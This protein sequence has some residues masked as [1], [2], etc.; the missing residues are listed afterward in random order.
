MHCPK[1]K[2]ENNRK[3][4]VI[5]ERQRYVCKS[6]NYYY[7]VE[8]RAGT[9]DQETKRRALE[10]YLEGLSLRTIGRLLKFSNVSILKWIRSFGAKVQDL[11][12][13]AP[14]KTVALDEMHTY[15]GSKKSSAGYRVLLIETQK[16]SSTGFKEELSEDKKSGVP[17]KHVQQEG[18]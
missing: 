11:K 8:H 5:K 18:S 4:G 15:I 7:T 10:L 2:K 6:C 17:S 1:C 3:S 14:T 12:T 9:A 16:D 13:H